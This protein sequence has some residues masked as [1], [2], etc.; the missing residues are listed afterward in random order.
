M[1]LLVFGGDCFFLREPVMIIF[2]NVIGYVMLAYLTLS[3]FNVLT[4]RFDYIEW[5]FW[6]LLVVAVFFASR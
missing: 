6:L 1:D 3:L 2:I 4:W 5:V